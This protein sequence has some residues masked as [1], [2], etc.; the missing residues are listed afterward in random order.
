MHSTQFINKSS[1]TIPIILQVLEKM[2]DFYENFYKINRYKAA[3]IWFS[4]QCRTGKT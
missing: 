4:T 1:Q 3:G 2:I